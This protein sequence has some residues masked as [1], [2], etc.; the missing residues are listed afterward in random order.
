MEPMVSSLCW[1]QFTRSSLAELEFHQNMQFQSTFWDTSTQNDICSWRCWGVCIIPSNWRF[2]WI[3]IC[4]VLLLHAN[5]A[6]QLF[7][8]QHDESNVERMW[9]LV[10]SRPIHGNSTSAKVLSSLAEFLPIWF[11]RLQPFVRVWA[12][13]VARNDLWSTRTKSNKIGKD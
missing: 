3:L 4:I 6:D 12:R 10:P 1:A 2:L 9:R 7:R 8:Y 5:N 13:S 11:G